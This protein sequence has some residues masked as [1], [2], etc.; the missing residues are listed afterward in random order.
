MEFHRALAAREDIDWSRI[1]AFAVDDFW[2]P[3]MPAACRVAAQPARDLYSRV[4]PRSI[5][6]VDPDAADPEAEARR[7]EELLREHPPHLACIGIGVSGHLAL[8]EPG[9]CRF[10]DERLVR[11][12]ELCPDSVRQLESDPNFRDLPAI[13]RTGI[14]CTVPAL[15][16]APRVLAVVPYGIKAPVIRRFFESPVGEELP[17]T[18]L[19]DKPGSALYLD[20][21]SF[22]ESRCLGAALGGA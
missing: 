18:A 9:A 20:A 12:A 5:N 19:K 10:D 14:T 13:P 4:E 11:V 7:Y 15:L 16:A 6:T 1:N 17:A 3:G 2:S 22:A 8:N 21:D